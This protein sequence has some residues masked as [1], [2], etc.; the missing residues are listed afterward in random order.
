MVHLLQSCLCS[1][2]RRDV[3]VCFIDIVVIVDHH[4]LDFLFIMIILDTL[5]GL[6]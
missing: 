6:I 2:L 5:A 3:I 4:C 1:V